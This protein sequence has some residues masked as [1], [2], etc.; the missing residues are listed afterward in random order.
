VRAEGSYRGP[1]GDSPGVTVDPSFWPS[2]LRNE[3]IS[4]YLPLNAL[5]GDSGDVDVNGYGGRGTTPSSAGGLET[6]ELVQ[7]LVQTPLYG[8][9]VAS[10][11]GEG[12][13]AVSVPGVGPPERSGLGLL[14]APHLLSSG[15]RAS[16]CVSTSL[17]SVFRSLRGS[18]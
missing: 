6:L 17:I 8:R 16:L 5:P 18:T 1:F 10:E 15:E 3:P 13:G 7:G 11:F 4:R 12:V 14:L 2:F 9:L